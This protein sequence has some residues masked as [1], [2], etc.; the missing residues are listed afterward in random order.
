MNETQTSEKVDRRR[1]RGPRGPRL[2]T[3]KTVFR[4]IAGINQ[5]YN[6]VHLYMTNIVRKATGLV[7]DPEAG[8][9]VEQESEEQASATI[10]IRIGDPKGQNE[11]FFEGNAKDAI[12]ILN[13]FRMGLRLNAYGSVADPGV[14][15]DDDD[16]SE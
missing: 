14:V 3:A 8:C 13:G 7:F 11:P 15:Q 5:S 1:R 10:V 16:D 6:H 9:M 2:Y 12:S 4:A